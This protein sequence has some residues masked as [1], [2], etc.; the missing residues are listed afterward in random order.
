MLRL[1]A[2]R[3]IRKSLGL[4][5]IRVGEGATF[6]ECGEVQRLPSHLV[7]QTLHPIEPWICPK[8]GTKHPFDILESYLNSDEPSA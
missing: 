6:C 4:D 1:W 3:L 7:V 5:Y 8:C 2:K